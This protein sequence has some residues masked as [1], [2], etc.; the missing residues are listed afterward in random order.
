MT[1]WLHR[2]WTHN[3]MERDLRAVGLEL[4]NHRAG[5]AR[6]A[7]PLEA[8]SGLGRGQHRVPGLD[9]TQELRTAFAAAVPEQV[10]ARLE[11]VTRYDYGREGLY[12]EVGHPC[13]RVGPLP[14]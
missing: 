10:L 2:N 14:D 8:P 6:I 5:E 7:G 12:V 11:R 3:G 9:L 1:I 4:T 13:T